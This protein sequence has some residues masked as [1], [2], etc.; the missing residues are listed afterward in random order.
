MV[1]SAQGWREA[2]YRDTPATSPA[3]A[4][5]CNACAVCAVSMHIVPGVIQQVGLPNVMRGEETQVLG[6]LQTCGPA[7]RLLIGLP[8]S[9]SKWVEVVDG[10]IT[11]FDTFMTGE[12][13]PC[14]ATQH[15]RAHPAT[16]GRSRPKRST[17]ACKWR[18][19]GRPA[20]RAVDHVQRS[21]PG[22]D[23]RTGAEQ[24][25]DY[26][27]GLL[28]GHE[29]AG[30]PAPPNTSRSSSSATR[31]SVPATNA[32]STLC[33]FARVSLASRPPSAACGNWRWPPGSFN[34]L[35]A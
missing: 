17:A 19:G 23:R 3:S 34:L 5:P 35:E 26:L 28:I 1:G 33:G 25:P 14:S 27:S 9:H 11:H 30:L 10:C 29:L 12:C 22:A 24:Q 32:P 6:V 7:A 13:S 18:V 8:G 20:R 15:S 21:H 31:H 2:A 4:R 16:A